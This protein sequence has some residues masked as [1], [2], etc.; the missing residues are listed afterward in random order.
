MRHVD[1]DA[2]PEYVAVEER[3]LEC[4]VFFLHQYTAVSRKENHTQH[5]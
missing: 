2:C 4:L 5:K 1:V 3:L